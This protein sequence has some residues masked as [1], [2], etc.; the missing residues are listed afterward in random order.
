MQFSFCLTLILEKVVFEAISTHENTNSESSS[1]EVSLEKDFSSYFSQKNHINEKILDHDKID[2]LYFRN[3]Q[4]QGIDERKPF[5][6]E[7]KNNKLDQSSEKIYKNFVSKTL[8][9]SENISFFNFLIF[10]YS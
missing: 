7:K 8:R 6:K 1:Y 4:K 5:I 9:T 3:D 2:N 10:E